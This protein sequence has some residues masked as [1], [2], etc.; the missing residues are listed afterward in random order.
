[1]RHGV[2]GRKFS[3]DMSARKALLNSLVNALL[4][5]GQIKTTLPKAKDLRG[6]VEPLITKAKTDSVASRREV[7]KTITDKTVLKHLFEN[8]APAM[9]KRPGGYTRVLK[10]GFRTGDAAPMAIIELV[11]QPKVAYSAGNETATEAKTEATSEKKAAAKPAAKKTAAKAEAGEAKAAA[12][13]PA[14]KKAAPKKAAK[15]AD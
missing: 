3:R 13:K 7:A 12:K 11:E 9:A 5:H 14:A 8:V 10:A 15:K 6:V 2:A 1:M 4:K